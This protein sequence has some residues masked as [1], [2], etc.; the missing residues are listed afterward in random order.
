MVLSREDMDRIVDEHFTF[1][2]NDDLD[3]VMSSL[4]DDNVRHEAIPSPVG[5]LTDRKKIRDYYAMLYAGF[6]GEKVSNIRRLYGNDFMVD[7]TLW[8]GEM[9][10]GKAFLLDGKTGRG[11]NKMLHVFVF[12][13]GKIAHEQVWVDLAAVQRY[14]G[15]LPK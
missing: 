3:G 7:E 5:E 6:R 2:A 4:T 13:D 10:D 9:L 1:E 11:A 12:R 14:A 15:V 8:E